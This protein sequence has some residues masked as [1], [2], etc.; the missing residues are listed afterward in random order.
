MNRIL[1]YEKRIK[2]LQNDADFIAKKMTEPN[3]TQE[4]FMKL[5]YKRTN[6][7]S[8]IHICKRKISF[9]HQGK[10]YLG[11]KLEFKIP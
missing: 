6:I 3:Q 8:D 4:D 1:K 7:I 10:G 2:E 9:I 11:E 5:H